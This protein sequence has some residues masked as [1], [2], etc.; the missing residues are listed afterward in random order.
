[1]LLMEIWKIQRRKK[2][3]TLHNLRTFMAS[4]FKKGIFLSPSLE[5]RA[6]QP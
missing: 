1:M 4:F 3:K 2:K 6:N 5:R